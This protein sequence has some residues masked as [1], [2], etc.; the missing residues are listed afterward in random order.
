VTS[1]RTHFLPTIF[2]DGPS[3][4]LRSLRPDQEAAVRAMLPA[5]EVPDRPGP[6]HRDLL[7]ALNPDP[8]ASVADL[9]R[10]LGCSTST[11]SRGLEVVAAAPWARFR[12]DLAHDHLGWE[13]EVQLNLRVPAGSLPAVVQSLSALP[14]LRLCCSTS[15]PAN[16]SAVLWLRRLYELD[17]LE[18]TLLDR[19]P[20][21]EVVDRWVVSRVVKRMGHV[22]DT[23]GR[24]LR[25]P[26]APFADLGTPDP[27]RP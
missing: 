18:H 23:D 17:T 26:A 11:V 3:W 6:L 12:L 13:A 25:A 10:R 15:G 20:R 7:T 21:T 24:H 22:L 19:H 14:D 1:T 27:P 5:R 4:R 9:A 2:V 8:R 16:L